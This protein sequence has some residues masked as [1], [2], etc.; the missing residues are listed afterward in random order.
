MWKLFPALFLL[1]TGAPADDLE[2]QVRRFAKVYAVVESEAADPVSPERAIYGGAIPAMLRPLDPHSVFFTAEQFEDLRKMQ[3]SVTRGFGS[4]VSLMPGRVIVLQTVPG[5]P[6][7]KAGLAPGDEILAI[8][9]IRLDRFTTDQLAGLLSQLKQSTVNMDVRRAG[10]EGLLQFVL[11]PE[12]MQTPSVERAFYVRPGIGYVRVTSFDAQTAS[13]L[14]KAIEKLG[15]ASLEGLILDLRKNPG[16]AVEAA[17]E[18]SAMFLKPGERLVTVRGRAIEAS[19]EHVPA[20]S[21]PYTFPLA[22]LVDAQT[23]SASEIV[24][25]SLQD[26]DRAIIIGQPTFGKGL[27]QRVFPLAEG[28]GLA[29]T[30]AYYYTPSGRSIQRPLATGQLQSAINSS[31]AVPQP[32]YRTDAGRIVTGGGGIRPDLLAAERPLTRLQVYL[33]A[34]GSFPLFATAYL[35]TSP[36]ITEDF[37]VTPQVVDDFRL[38]LSSRGVVTTPGDWSTAR[39]WIVLRLKIEIFN[40]ALGVEKGDEVDAR[41]DPAVQAALGVLGVQ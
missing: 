3:E 8:N 1:A 2:E 34:S 39:D 19:D 25:G 23:A 15:G 32:D 40:Q 37:E 41:R 13:D 10:S 4:I 6:S 30:T 17:L 21:T 28:T 29:L 7:A 35:K 16:G 24:A 11:N 22:V 12:D 14:R 18:T 38:Y 31:N 5:S 26:H 33:D 36:G 27:V 9:G 20:T